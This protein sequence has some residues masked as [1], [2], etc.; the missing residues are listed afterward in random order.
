MASIVGEGQ[1]TTTPVVLAQDA[2][3]G[4]K[5]G[6]SYSCSCNGK[7]IGGLIV[8]V[9]GAAMLIFAVLLAAGLFGGGETGFVAGGLTVGSMILFGVG[10]VLA[11]PKESNGMIAG[12]AKVQL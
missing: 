12:M 5:C 3:K 9:A 8:L 1:G 7:Q 11:I 10:V 4:Q 6:R 2:Q